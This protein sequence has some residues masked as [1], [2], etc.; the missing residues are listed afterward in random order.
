MSRN[1]SN[2]KAPVRKKLMKLKSLA[3][4][5][6]IEFEL[7]STL[8]TPAEQFAYF[9]Q[10]RNSLPEVNRLRAEAG[11]SPITEKEN[12]RPVTR[13]MNSAHLEGRAFD[14]AIVRR[15]NISKTGAEQ[16][17]PLR[18]KNEPIDSGV[19]RRSGATKQSLQWDPKTDVNKNQIPDYVELGML[20][21]SIGLTWG[22][23][24]KSRDFVHFELREKEI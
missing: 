3:K 10:G 6:G 9:A 7:T 18:P 17:L 2:L 11:L 1:I 16:A 20:A 5:K 13:T 14:L 23:R 22:G 12:Q 8:R 24:F 21:E 19:I 4:E 15:G